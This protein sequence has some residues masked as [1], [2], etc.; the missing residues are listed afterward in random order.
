MWLKNK[1]KAGKNIIGSPTTYE[2]ATDNPPSDSVPDAFQKKKGLFSLFSRSGKEATADAEL[3]ESTSQ[4]SQP[5]RKIAAFMGKLFQNIKKGRQPRQ[6]DATIQ[7]TLQD[8][9]RQ[10][11]PLAQKA[12][13][14]IKQT[15]AKIEGAIKRLRKREKTSEDSMQ[16]ALMASADDTSE[17]D[18]ASPA[19]KKSFLS[20]FNNKSLKL[21]GII[22]AAVIL[23]GGI[24]VGAYF[25][26]SQ[27]VSYNRQIT[28]LT[29][30]ITAYQSIID[31]GF[32]QN[33]D[34]VET[35]A[36]YQ[37]KL[38]DYS[39]FGVTLQSLNDN[40]D[41]R[42]ALGKKHNE[43]IGIDTLETDAAALLTQINTAQD[44]LNRITEF[45][46]ELSS[47]CKTQDDTVADVI[48]Q[49]GA[50]D[51]KPDDLNQAFH[52]IALP[53][54]LSLR[55][56]EV[57]SAIKAL[58]TSLDTSVAYFTD[59]EPIEAKITAL[60]EELRT[61]DNDFGEGLTLMVEYYS[62]KCR[63]LSNIKSALDAVNENASYTSIV[64]KID[65]SAFLISDDV[66]A[67]GAM[68]AFLEDMTSILDD[69]TALEKKVGATVKDKDMSN[70]DKQT[71][72]GKL[73]DQNDD[74][75]SLLSETQVPE[76][77]ARRVDKLKTALE[78]RSEALGEYIEYLKDYATY[79]SYKSKANSYW[80]I[81]DSNIDSALFYYSHGY[82]Y[83]CSTYLDMAEDAANDAESYDAKAASAKKDYVAHYDRYEMLREEYRETMG[84]KKN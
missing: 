58:Q 9:A 73:I 48:T 16:S 33:N 25:V 81:C 3:P 83:S 4:H 63:Q 57:Y 34:F 6:P 65:I 62:E 31:H 51:G 49:L 22:A 15:L 84:Y 27:T 64:K 29:Q 53:K 30:D 50:F 13:L 79:S 75:L 56:D 71:K 59:L 80:R 41:Y 2:H 72:T 24:G 17:V 20:R 70:K 19:A 37:K 26:I 14:L 32:E 69:N 74:M 52:E 46:Q 54:D 38:A 36:Q 82:Y 1:N 18:M 77:F 42:L 61:N 23:L 44:V 7:P 47:V 12:T 35:V 39:A 76:V 28:A 21:A 8:N 66:A 68:P 67:L 11:P 10:A 5:T 45:E 78:K 60:C 43:D 55:T 40:Q